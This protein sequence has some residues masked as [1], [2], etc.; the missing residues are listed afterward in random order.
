MRTNASAVNLSVLIEEVAEIFR[1]QSQFDGSSSVALD[2]DP[3][4]RRDGG[5]PLAEGLA[6]NLRSNAIESMKQGS[7]PEDGCIAT[8]LLSAPED[9]AQVQLGVDRKAEGGGSASG[10]SARGHAVREIEDTGCGSLKRFR[11]RFLNPSITTKRDG[12]ELGLATVHRLAEQQG[13]SIYLSSLVAVGTTYRVR[14][15]LGEGDHD[16]D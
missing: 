5:F 4:S 3:Q 16:I 6:W 2:L 14:L 9:A 7:G 13:G 12:T 10:G 8:Q 1:S 15:L 11:N